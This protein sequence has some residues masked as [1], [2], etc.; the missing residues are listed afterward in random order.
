[1][2]DDEMMRGNCLGCKYGDVALNKYPCSVCKWIQLCYDK[3]EARDV[4]SKP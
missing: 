2:N 3:W 4:K 1:M